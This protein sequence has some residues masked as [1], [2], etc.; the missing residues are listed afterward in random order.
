MAHIEQVHTGF[1]VVT[2][3]RG[4]VYRDQGSERVRPS[5]TLKDRIKPLAVKRRT[6]CVL[7]AQSA[8]Q[9]QEFNINQPCHGPECTHAHH[10]R[11]R[12][13]RLIESGD[14]RW[15][16]NG[17][18]VAAWVSDPNWRGVKSG[19]GGRVK[20]M[21]ICDGRGGLDEERPMSPRL[22]ARLQ[23]EAE[24]VKAEAGWQA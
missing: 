11:N 21:Q 3:V 18:N 5:Q 17:E 14:L 23:L 6:V 2:H 7:S 1:K 19:E 15:V 22:R 16:G 13:R 20:V 10:T 12:I 8:A 24:S 4:R 9:L